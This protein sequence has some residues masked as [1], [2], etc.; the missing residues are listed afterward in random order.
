[1]ISLWENNPEPPLSILNPTYETYRSF[2]ITKYIPLNELQSTLVEAIHEPTGARVMH[3]A[4]DDPENLFCLSFQTL[5]SRSNGVAHILEHIVLCGSDKFPVKDPFFAM[6]RRSLNTY[7]NAL[8]G[9]DFTCY[10]ASS[11]VEKDF[12]NLLSVYLDAVFHPELKKMSFLQEGHR[13]EFAEPKNPQSPLQFQ[14]VVY[15]EMKGSLSSAD[16]RLWE[17]VMKHLTPDLPYAANSGGN[18]KEIPSLTYEE[19]KNFHNIFYHPSRCLFFF[20][21]NIPLAKHLDFLLENELEKTKKQAPLPPIPKQE[22]FKTPIAVTECY[23]IEASESTKNKTWVVF[24]WLTAPLI[25]QEEVLALCLLDSILMDTD[26]STLKMALLKSGLCTSAESSI[27]TEMSEIP[28]TVV[29]KGCEKENAPLLKQILFETLENCVFKAEDIEASLHQLEF[30]RTEI[31][32]EGV[33]FGLSLFFRAGLTKQHG[34]EAENALLI[35]T[36]FR[37]LRARLQ[38]SDYL[39]SLLRKYLIDNPHFV[40]LTFIPDPQL[41]A[42]ERLEEEE[43]LKALRPLINEKALIEQAEQLANYQESIET[44]SL[45]C[46][47]KLNLSDVPATARDFP[48]KET[49]KGPLQ[50][51]HHDCF[52]N[53][54]LYADLV[55]DLPHIPAKDLGLVSL[56]SRFM[57]ELGCGDRNYE[58]TLSYQQAYTGGVGA[59]LALHMFQQN[60]NVCRPSFSLKGK[61]LARYSDKL[62][63]LFIDLAK[64]VRCNDAPRIKE[65]LFQSATILQNRLTKNSLNYAIQQALKGFSAASFIFDEWNGLSYYNQILEWA[66]NPELLPQELA[67]IQDL[68]LSKGTPHLVLSCEANMFSHLQEKNF[69]GLPE[70]LK[71]SSLNP[72][73]NDYTLPE[74]SSVARF[75][76][77][78]VAFTAKGLRTI[79]YNDPRSAFLLIA[80]E[81]LEN[82]YLHKQV[83]EK[84]GAYG[85]GASYAPQ[86][87]NFHFYSYRDPNLSKTIDA[88]EKAIEKIGGGHF[89]EAELE[90]AKFGVI[91]SIDEPVPP[92]SRAMIAYAWKRSGRTF[93][94]RQAFRQNIL[95]AKKQDVAQAVRELLPNQPSCIVSFLGEDLYKKESKKLKGPLGILPVH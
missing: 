81:L 84:G 85:S 41:D 56:Y 10:P 59:S 28:L 13:L 88:F 45:D 18:P 25:H 70:Q 79:S 21:G 34:S 90:E 64:G 78:P 39:P 57:T 49:S 9:Q 20:Y 22:R 11:Q 47:P 1:M 5:P 36:L 37:D 68:I 87:G 65:L 6:T 83:R 54:I 93:S 63:S 86:T 58:E 92:G 52:T 40:E 61:C 12:Y 38:D 91:Q 74:T 75:I 69:F 32:A 19:L 2:R 60:P 4:N 80:T 27:D 14:G 94:D 7:M 50:I 76:A 17:A 89:T 3:I 66:K 48:L 77:S 29:C 33:P 95:N 15:N 62:F 71:C 31:G 30:Q 43:K 72:W 44:Q 53:Q 35:H 8:T 26:A 16:S 82:C 73:T 24:S 51:F 67:R 23:P 42:K 46:L 55:F